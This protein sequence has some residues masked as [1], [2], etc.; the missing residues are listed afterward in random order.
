MLSQ[1]HNEFIDINFLRLC[2]I[3]I[4]DTEPPVWNEIVVSLQFI[5]VAVL[6]CSHDL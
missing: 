4:S 6:S 2:C 5:L 3:F 1:M